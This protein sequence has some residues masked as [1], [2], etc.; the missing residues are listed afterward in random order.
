MVINWLWLGCS[1]ERQFGEGFKSENRHFELCTRLEHFKAHLDALSA[2]QISNLVGITITGLDNIFADLEQKEK[3][4]EKV[5]SGIDSFFA[6]V[7]EIRKENVKIMFGP[8]LMWKKHSKEL[9]STAAGAIKTLKVKYPGIRVVQ[10]LTSLKFSSDGVHL[11]ERS[12]KIHFGAVQSASEDFFYNEDDEYYT[13][14]ESNRDDVNMETDVEIEITKV[15]EPEIQVIKLA[16]PKNDEKIEDEIDE[17]PM[18]HSINNPAFAALLAEV[19]TVKHMMFERWLVDL[20]VSAGTKEDLDRI[21]NNANMNKIVISGIEVEGIWAATDWK[22]RVPLIKAAIGPLFKLIDPEHSKDIGYIKHLN[23]RLKG[24]RQIIEVTMGSEAEGKAIRKKYAERVREWREAKTF[25]AKVHG[26]SIAP[27]LTLATR[28]RVAMLHA[29]A[30]GIKKCYNNKDA[31]VIQHV[32]R[33]V[34]KIETTQPD[35]TKVIQSL[36]FAQA[37][38][39]TLKELPKVKLSPQDLFDAYSIAGTRFGPELCHYFVILSIDQAEK[40]EKSKRTK[41]K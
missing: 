39:H 14:V 20:I 13:D 27:A 28:V 30:K 40:I 24:A 18:Q 19:K 41:K 37:I 32:A 21:E 38:A 1:N 10:K 34:I 11:N 22:A 2:E 12:A 29:M 25:P 7:E 17:E 31:W 26:V 5:E 6:R 4:M 8:L 35:N 33:P 15:V 9:R 3:T 23:G 36:G 16:R